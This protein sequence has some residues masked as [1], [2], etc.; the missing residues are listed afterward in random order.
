[1]KKAEHTITQGGWLP[2]LHK[3][4]RTFRSRSITV[5]CLSG[6]L[7]VLTAR[8]TADLTNIT[9][10]TTLPLFLLDL[11]LVF[12]PPPPPPH[13]LPPT[14]LRRPLPLPFLS[15]VFSTFSSPEGPGRACQSIKRRDSGHKISEVRG[16]SEK[17]GDHSRP[18]DT[19]GKGGNHGS[20]AERSAGG[21][22][23]VGEGVGAVS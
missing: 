3:R 16:V 1:M 23:K 21:G 22:V 4:T 10:T 9:T 15:S 18:I 8:D 12:S 2:P 14:P 7:N 11:P 6:L 17:F 5:T 19:G 13:P 20:R